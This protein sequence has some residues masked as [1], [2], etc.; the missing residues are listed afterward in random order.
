MR[1]PAVVV[2]WLRR[3]VVQ[4]TRR[5]PDYIIQPDG[6]TVYLR[7]WWIIPRNH[8][9]NIYA[10]EILRSDDDRALHDHPWLNCSLILS[11]GY[12]EHTIDAGGVHKRQCYSEGDVK[13]R[14][15]R[16]AHRLEIGAYPAL[17]LFLT[18]PIIRKWGFHCPHGWRHWKQFVDQKGT[19]IGRGCD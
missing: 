12:V 18:G 7:R 13:F 2:R 1:L 4:R 11:G 10:H 16:A 8:L 19:A 9:F 5:E 3:A 17:T 6:R 14:R 15:A